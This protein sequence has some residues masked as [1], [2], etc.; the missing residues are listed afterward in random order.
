MHMCGCCIMSLFSQW[1]ETFTVSDYPL[2]SA[3]LFILGC[4]VFVSHLLV[5][6]RVSGCTC[7]MMHDGA[8]QLGVK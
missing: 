5:H 2:C 3:V 4:L 7:H 8:D 1:E 6:S